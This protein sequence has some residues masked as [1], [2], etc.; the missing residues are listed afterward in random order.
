M[1]KHK[2]SSYAVRFLLLFSVAFGC[3]QLLRAQHPGSAA[4][5]VAL[6]LIGFSLKD[7]LEVSQLRQRVQAHH[8]GHAIRTLSRVHVRELIRLSMV[9]MLVPDQGTV[10]PRQRRQALPFLLTLRA[11]LFLR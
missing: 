5:G 7:P 3:A 10:G 8:L 6:R 1:L 2:L 9:L 4:S 11:A